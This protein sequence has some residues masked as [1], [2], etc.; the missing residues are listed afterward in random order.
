MCD[1]EQNRSG[2]RGSSLLG[3]FGFDAVSE[4]VASD[5]DQESFIFRKFSKLAARNLIAMQN[6]LLHLEQR[7]ERLDREVAITADDILCS[8]MRNFDKFKENLDSRPDL[9]KRKA[10]QDEIELKLEKYCEI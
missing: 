10:V 9:Q 2:R 8:A 7:Q 4:F 1:L 5:V 6:E 3:T